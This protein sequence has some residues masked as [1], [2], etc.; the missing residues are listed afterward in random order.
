[1]SAA[2]TSPA[3]DKRA[4]LKQWLESGEI[5]LHPLT[6]PQRELWEASPVPPG[7]AVNHICCLITVRGAITPQDIRAAIQLVV[8][9]QDALRLSILPGKERP[10]QMIRRTGEANFSVRE[11]PEGAI[12]PEEIE[13]RAREVFREPFDMVQGPLYRVELLRC[14]A[15]HQVLVFAIHHSIADGWTLGI[16]VQDLCAA[17]L[18]VVRGHRGPLPKVEQSYVA[19]GAA[20]RAFWQPAELERRAAFW[21]QRLAGILPLW[22]AASTEAP[23]RLERWVTPLLP[24]I[25]AAAREL[26][27][28]SGT[29]L[30]SALLTAFQVALHAWKGVDD[31]VVGSPIANRNKQVDRET[32]GSYAGIV[33]LRGKIQ[34][35]RSFSEALKQMH[36]TAVDCFAQAMPF[37]ELAKA[38]RIAPTTGAHPVFD[39]RFALQNHPVPDVDLPGLSAKLRMRSTGTARFYLGCELTEEGNGMEIAWLYR[40]GMFDEEAVRELNRLF[41]GVLAAAS[42]APETKVA[43]LKIV[44]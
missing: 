25:T 6:F 9:R 39:T 27:R 36:E 44:P 23:R 43:E 4:R 29:T 3:A 30:F 20:E 18:Q 16:F 11:F 41:Q 17:Y 1:V 42:R 28:R 8:E 31:I 40:P 33:P 34:P 2:I 12:S 38:L 21:K 35:Q 15:D 7:D 19:W 22:G 10:L 26:A 32:M 13:G 5:V 37:V 14:A 24:D